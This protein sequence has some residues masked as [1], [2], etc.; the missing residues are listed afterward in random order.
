MFRWLAGWCR[1][2][3]V[4]CLPGGEPQ[5]HGSAMAVAD[6][7]RGAALRKAL[8]WLEDEDVV[9]ARCRS[10]DIESRLEAGGGMCV[11]DDFLP[12]AVA[13]V[14][15][16][17]GAHAPVVPVCV[18]CAAW[19]G[20]RDDRSR[21]SPERLGP[22]GVVFAACATNLAVSLCPL[23]AIIA[24]SCRAKSH[25]GVRGAGRGAQAGW[26]GRV[27]CC[28]RVAPPGHTRPRTGR[29]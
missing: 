1:V 13:E 19:H 3:T 23:A 16:E 18:M 22:F 24:D 17:V 9:E 12:A 2:D 25:V 21:C 8:L 15:L 27:R 28:N 11:I 10:F 14:A 5:L 4:Q 26:L 29:G 20:V 7:T 6:R